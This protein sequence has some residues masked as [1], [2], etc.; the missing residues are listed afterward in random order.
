MRY[1][2]RLFPG[3]TVDPSGQYIVNLALPI[4]IGPT[5]NIVLRRRGSDSWNIAYPGGLGALGIV[6]FSELCSRMPND[7]ELILELDGGELARESHRCWVPYEVW[8]VVLEMKPMRLPV[9]NLRLPYVD[10][11]RFSSAWWRMRK[12][13]HLGSFP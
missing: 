12:G 6:R 8:V 11:P 7:C 13:A 3:E 1:T 4:A 9:P 10:M 5:N 2:R